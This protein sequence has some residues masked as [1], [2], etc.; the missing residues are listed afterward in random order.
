M[1]VHREKISKVGRRFYWKD[2]WSQGCILE[3]WRPK[4]T[5]RKGSQN[6][7]KCVSV[8]VYNTWS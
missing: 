1:S 3:F 7:A 5:L 6:I 2:D 8:H 4:Q